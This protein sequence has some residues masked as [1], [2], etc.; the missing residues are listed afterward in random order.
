MEQV[1]CRYL[2]D[3]YMDGT[4]LVITNVW[5]I[6]E[7]NYT[8][9][10]V[11][12]K[13]GHVEKLQISVTVIKEFVECFHCMNYVKGKPGQHPPDNCSTLSSDGVVPTVTCMSSCVTIVAEGLEGHD[14]VSHFIKRDCSDNAILSTIASNRT[15]TK[16]ELEELKKGFSVTSI[17]SGR[18]GVCAEN[19][20]NNQNANY[21]M[22]QTSADNNAHSS[23]SQLKTLNFVYFI[24]T[25]TGSLV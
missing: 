17:Y 24:I 5:E 10:A 9:Q 25:F 4:N 21:Q 2:D 8:C 13:C 6:H 16:G 23:T 3:R 19:H 1:F 11:F 22:V 15:L 20:C 18:V 14:L 7:G 12:R